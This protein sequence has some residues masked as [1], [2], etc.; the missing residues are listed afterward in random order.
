[1]SKL[2]KVILEFDD[3]ILVL[4]DEKDVEQW[5]KDISTMSSLAYVHGMSR[6]NFNWKEIKK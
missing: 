3:K 2:I 5:D 4:E 6:K 1:M